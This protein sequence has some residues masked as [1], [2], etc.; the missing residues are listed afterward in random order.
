MIFWYLA[1]HLIESTILPLEI[2]FEHRMY[3]P[4]VALAL[5]TVLIGFDFLSAYIDNQKLILLI[6]VI[7]LMIT[8]GATYT[9]N[10]DFKDALTFYR[11]EIKKFPSSRRLRMDLAVTLNRAGEY[12][13]GGKRLAK[14][15]EDY[16]NDI[17][18][19][20]NWY[21]FVVIIEKNLQKSELIYQDIIRLIRQGHYDKNR[22][23]ESLRKLA[24]YL[25]EN[26]EFERALFLL[27]CLLKDYRIHDSLWFQKGLCYVGLNDWD[28][29]AEMFFQAWKI[30]PD[31]PAILYWYGKVLVHLGELD[32]GCQFLKKAA[33]NP[34][35]K[36][37][38]VLSQD[39]LKEACNKRFE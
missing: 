38:V 21:N 23:A 30:R 20:Q 34:I 19:R 39:L 36:E 5:G 32:K 10:L 22:D 3:L 25:R 6:F 2:I 37:G 26:G 28:L 8:G 13:E 24:M 9:R 16:P 14:L 35:D 15:A 11:A 17:A 33:R 1:G 27:D 31:D 4:S 7:S 18:I 29:A 12:A